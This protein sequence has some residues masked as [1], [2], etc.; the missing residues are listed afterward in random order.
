MSRWFALGSDG[1]MYDLCDCGDFEAAEESAEDLLPTGT[2]VIWLVDEVTALEW[3][4]R[5]IVGVSDGAQHIRQ[6]E[7]DGIKL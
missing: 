3:A 1:R 2:G 4:A 5:I 7:K 6:L